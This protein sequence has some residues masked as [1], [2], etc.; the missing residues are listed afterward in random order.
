MFDKNYKKIKNV[1][2]ILLFIE[3]K[4][5][6]C[7]LMLSKRLKVLGG[8]NWLVCCVIVVYRNVDYVIMYILI[9]FIVVEVLRGLVW[10]F[11]FFGFFM[12]L[13]G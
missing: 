11:E 2:N 8:F 3:W 4:V 10:N 9:V 6:F 13:N 7:I 5:L 1:K 12:Y